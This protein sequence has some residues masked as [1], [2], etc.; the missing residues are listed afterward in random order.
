VPRIFRSKPFLLALVTA[1]ILILT[2]LARPGGGVSWLKE[3]LNTPLTPIA[4]FFT[5]VKGS[6]DDFFASFRDK[7]E[8][9]EEL[10]AYKDRV[11][12]LEKGIMDSSRLEEDNAM[13]RS[14]LRMREQLD[15]YETL[16]A[17]VVS[18]V[19]S[20]W[21]TVF[22]I[23]KGTWDG[24]GI[25]SIVV[26]YLGLV[27]LVVEVG[28]KTAKVMAIINVDSTVSGSIAGKETTLA[29]V[30]GDVILRGESLLRMDMID[31]D[32]S[33]GVGDQVVTSGYGGF[34]PGGILIGSVRSIYNGRDNFERY[35]VIEPA[36]D[37]TRIKEV[38]V[39]TKA[40]TEGGG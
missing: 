17:F 30:Q 26:N 39:L 16:G 29:R 27:G 31:S 5:G 8:L 36:V 34:Y 21:F 7:R 4:N 38:M 6:I 28:P 40:E 35:A 19:Q 13:L 37:F 18:K 15:E 9:Q 2:F 3:A 20:N 23:D 12:E 11:A 22:T 25:N 32:A 33:V 1:L 24:V 14:L 10:K